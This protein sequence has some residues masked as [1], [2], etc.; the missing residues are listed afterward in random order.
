MKLRKK[1]KSS[2]YGKKPAATNTRNLAIENIPTRDEV[3]ME[4]A[5]FRPELPKSKES[6]KMRQKAC[7]SGYGKHTAEK[8]KAEST[9]ERPTFRP[10]IGTSPA[11]RKIMKQVGS[12][13]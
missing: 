8:K 7:S 10:V 11:A 9:V 6:V 2:K 5:T 13:G 1:V 3:E 4:G 12:S